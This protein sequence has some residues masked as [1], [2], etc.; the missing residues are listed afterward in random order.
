M[1]KLPE[2]KPHRRFFIAW[3]CIAA[4]LVLLAAATYLSAG[5]FTA[6]ISAG[7]WDDFIH[8]RGVAAQVQQAMQ[9]GMPLD[10][11]KAAL[12]QQCHQQGMA[13]WDDE[14]RMIVANM[15]RAARRAA[16][17]AVI[18]LAVF[19][20]LFAMPSLSRQ[21]RMLLAGAL[22]AVLLFDLVNIATKFILPERT[23]VTLG[24]PEA[25]RKLLTVDRPFRV[26]LA[27][28][29]LKGVGMYN[30]WV[31]SL[32]NLHGIET[33][34]VPA[35]SRPTPDHKL[36]FYS[37]ALSPGRRWQYGNV[38]FLLGPKDF[39]ERSLRQLGMRNQC[40]PFSE[41]RAD[42]GMHAIYELTNALP[43]MFAVGSWT[44]ITNAI[45]ALAFMN[46]S[47]TD[48]H[49][50]A[51][52]MDAAY[53]PRTSTNFTGSIVITRYAPER[54]EATATLSGE[55]IVVMATEPDPGWTA[56]VDGRQEKIL[57]CNLLHQG[58]IVPAGTHAIVFSFHTGHWTHTLNDAA[59]V[60]L[61]V[62][63]VATLA[64]LVVRKRAKSD[65]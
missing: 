59:Y 41:H 10:Q 22:I 49:T 5:S 21:A 60:A 17:L 23:S 6:S 47:G 28:P 56:T 20:A 34:D 11:V 57:R 2:H 27:S 18:A 61:P 32:F 15:Q 65:G 50:S 38:R 36:F 12:T 54:I 55:G 31:S 44:V 45:Q 52:L 58:V 29:G 63:A 3:A 51:V 35:D 8:T 53:P 48:P 37:D 1:I 4:A 39:L 40:V 9:Q 16:V 33:I 62:L 7:R 26:A 13:T 43:R 64:W 14:A 46:A 42:D 24:T 25:F 30:L 19:Y